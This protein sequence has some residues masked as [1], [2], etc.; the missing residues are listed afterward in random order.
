MWASLQTDVK[1]GGIFR[2]GPGPHAINRETISTEQRATRTVLIHRTPKL[3]KK[4]REQNDSS[5]GFEASWGEKT[6][7]SALQSV[8]FL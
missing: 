3:L 5:E 1:L 2:K 8:D 7:H 6:L 4:G